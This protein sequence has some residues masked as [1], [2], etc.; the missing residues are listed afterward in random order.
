[1]RRYAANRDRYRLVARLQIRRHL[2]VDLIQPGISRRQ[3]AEIVGPFS[4][5]FSPPMVTV[6]VFVVLHSGLPSMGAAS[7]LAG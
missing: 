4:T 5:T 1:L 2:E 3:T 7:P 6:T